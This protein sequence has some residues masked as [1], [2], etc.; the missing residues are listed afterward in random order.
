MTGPFSTKAKR[1]AVY[2]EV[3][4]FLRPLGCSVTFEEE[5]PPLGEARIAISHEKGPSTSVWIDRKDTILMAHVYG[6]P[7][8]LAR[9]VALLGDVNR[10]HRRKATIYGA[11]ADQLATRLA[12]LYAL[13][14][15]GEAYEKET[16]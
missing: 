13:V 12:R 5:A 10:Y 7:A 8:P 6:S 16:A 2:N 15:S 1:R 4:A 9:E 3:D 11:D 14:E